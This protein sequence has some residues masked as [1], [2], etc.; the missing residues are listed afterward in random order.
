MKSAEPEETEIQIRTEGDRSN[1]VL[2][3]LPGLHGD[4]TLLSAFA[5][6]AREKFFLVEITYPRTLSWSLDQYAD[7]VSK[8]IHA[9][10]IDK[11]WILA[12]SFS[13][14][15]AWAWLKCV[16]EGADGFQPAGIILAGG[17]VKFPARWIVRMVGM[18]F[19]VTPWIVW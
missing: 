14:Q 8:A 10:G 7:A 19:D 2:I 1:P 12:E 5:T 16:Q 15:I 3:Y 9:T 17:F 6:L 18:F 11:G 4:W 13:S